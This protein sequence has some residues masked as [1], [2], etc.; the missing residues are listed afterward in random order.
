MVRLLLRGISRIETTSIT[1]LLGFNV[2]ILFVTVFCRYLLNN[3]PTWPEEASRYVMIWIV[4]LGA[5]QSIERNAEIKI[6][7]L[8]KLI[9][10]RFLNVLTSI[11]SPCAGLAIALLIVYQG[12]KFTHILMGMEQS[13]ASFALSMSF[14]YAIVPV[15]GFLMAVK[16]IVTL[17]DLLKNLTKKR[18]LSSDT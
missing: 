11:F 15:S 10:S 2:V 12:V 9:P 5:S 3:P 7:A 6:D 17:I 16:Y 8:P 4:Y 18:V 1:V 14:I 13:A